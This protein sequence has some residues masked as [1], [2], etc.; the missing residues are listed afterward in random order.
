MKLVI[1]CKQNLWELRVVEEDGGFSAT[2]VPSSGY[3]P[4]Q[5]LVDLSPVVTK[6]SATS[7]NYGHIGRPG[8]VGGSGVV[9]V[10]YGMGDKVRKLLM[11][12]AGMG[13][14]M[15]YINMIPAVV[16]G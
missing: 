15:G 7:G 1:V 9:D 12:Y 2:I 8:K 13:K 11:D 5:F 3:I 6:G 16:H 10:Q 4:E 14:F